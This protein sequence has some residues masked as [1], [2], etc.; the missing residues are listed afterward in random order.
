MK[1]INS[2]VLLII[3]YTLLVVVHAYVGYFVGMTVSVL[4]AVV[5]GIEGVVVAN[6]FAWLFVLM[7]SIA[8]VM[9][10]ILVG[11]DALILIPFKKEEDREKTV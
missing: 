4:A 7:F 10:T 8:M 2:F 6:A 3:S 5:L 9:V 1:F 11:S